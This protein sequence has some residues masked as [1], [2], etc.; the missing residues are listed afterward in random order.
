MQYFSHVAY[1]IAGLQCRPKVPA[2]DIQRT[3]SKPLLLSAVLCGPSKAF[4]AI[5][6]RSLGSSTGLICYAHEVRSAAVPEM[7]LD[8]MRGRMIILSILIST[9]PGKEMSMIASS[10]RL[11]GRRTNPMKVPTNTPLTVRTSSRLFLI[12][13]SKPNT[14]RLTCAV[15]YTRNTRTAKVK[16]SHC[17]HVESIKQW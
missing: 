3:T 2:T 16:T 17:E 15:I 7:R 12:H 1:S 11:C 6:L 4:A 14:T 10:L 13:R 9:S 8:M 5:P